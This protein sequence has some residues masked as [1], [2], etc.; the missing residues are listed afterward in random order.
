MPR[1]PWQQSGL[2]DDDLQDEIRAHLAIAADERVAGGVDRVSAERASRKDFGNVTLIRDAVRTVWTP[3]WVDALRDQFQDVRYAVRVLAK[4]PAFSLTVVLVLTLGIALNTAVFTLFK[5]LALNP[6]SGITDSSRLGVVIGETS[7]GRQLGLSYHDYQYVRDHDQAFEGLAASALV[8]GSVGQGK[9]AERA[10]AELVSGNYFQALGVRTVLGRPLLPSDEVAPGRHPVAVLGHGL[11]RRTFGADPQIIGKTIYLNAYPLTVVGVADPAFHGIVV[12]FDVEVFAP[13]MMAPQIGVGFEKDSSTILTDRRAG[14]LMVLGRPRPGLRLSAAAAQT[15]VLSSQL[16]REE[17]VTDVAERLKVIRIWQSPY[18]AQTYLLPS[19]LVLGAMGLLLLLIV[20]ANIAGLVLVRGVSRRGEIGVR[21]AL[22]A[23]RARILRL[24]FVENLMLTIPGTVIGL[25]LLWGGLPLLW[26]ATSLP[27]SSGAPGRMFMNVTIDQL[28]VGFSIFV[29]CASAIV[30]GF[31]PALHSSAVDLNSV[32]KEDA[33][34]RG[35]ARGRLRASLVVAQVA[36]SLLLLV[37]SGLVTRS[38]DA[39]RTVNPGFEAKQVVSALLDLKPSGYD[40]PRGRLF[41]RHLLDATRATAGIESVTLA[42]IYPMSTVD[43]GVQ[44]VAIDGYEPHKD[45]DLRF[46][47]NTVGPDYFHTLRIPL[48]SGRDFR[49]D[50]DEGAAP[51]AI[52]NATLARRFWGSDANAIG[53]RVRPAYGDWRTIVGVA[54]DVKY[55]RINEAPR[56]YVYVPF[57]QSYQSAMYLHA[58]G[59]DAMNA[60]LDQTR[61]AITA[62]D[63]NLPQNVRPL[64]EL[65]N[66]SL[67]ILEF[68]ALMLFI[69]GLAG[70]AL[71]AMGIYG[72]VSYT[73]KQSTHEIGIRMA[74]GAS[75]FSVVRTFLGRGLRLGMLGAA[76]GIVT[77]FAVSRLIASVLFG[78]SATDLA[79]F[80]TAL[81]IVLGGVLLATIVPAYRAARTNP[82]AALR[83]Q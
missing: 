2:D 8:L 57:L 64:E 19:V 56:P 68:A 24:L 45:E 32:M 79:S 34:P 49:E 78:V 51:V 63:A 43:Y 5:S 38:L 62:L 1:W 59:T 75:S 10:M 9:Q 12:S 13:L 18:G 55:S 46:L 21:L 73:V 80:G 77:A 30:F 29:A 11:W 53:K 54:A 37:G 28:V 6:L 20:C 72:L 69:F 61:A 42:A 71:A 60:H 67:I 22:G 36:V 44:Q 47:S 81:S 50:D 48:L 25:L 70:M 76:L 40:E 16:A 17:A 31:V 15:A 14:F 26:S 3:R 52:V 41:Y 7:S 83:H 23:T 74:L 35:G 27:G 39:A 58:R 4:S 82:L 66:G 65:T 33:S